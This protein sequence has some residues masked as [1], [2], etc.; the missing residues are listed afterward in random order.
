MKGFRMSKRALRV[1]IIV[2]GAAA[3]GIPA[4]RLVSAGGPALPQE[5]QAI[6]DRVDAERAAGVSAPKPSDPTALRPPEEPEAPWTTGIVEDGEAPFPSSD[7]T[8][9]NR[10]QGRID[11]VRVVVYAG[12]LAR[13]ARQGVVIVARLG[14]DLAEVSSRRYLTPVKAGAVKIARAAG[15]RLALESVSGVQSLFDVSNAAFVQA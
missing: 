12:A 1:A 3:L 2:V 10:W 13:D 11:G 4:A 5:K 7:V 8:I 14:A 9:L 6:L 15:D